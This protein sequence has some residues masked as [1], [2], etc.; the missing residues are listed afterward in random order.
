M[1]VVP[2]YCGFR[3][4]IV[5][6]YGIERKIF[7]NPELLSGHRILPPPRSLA[8]VLRS[9][10]SKSKSCSIPGILKPYFAL[11]DGVVLVLDN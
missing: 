8:K 9:K 6:E 11:L 3:G 10:K 5:L 2:N 4:N 7:Q 1:A